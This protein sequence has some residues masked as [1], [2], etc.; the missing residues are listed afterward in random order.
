MTKELEG[1]EVP[2]Q[3]RT[4]FGTFTL[5]AA[6]QSGALLLFSS[7]MLGEIVIPILRMGEKATSSSKCSRCVDLPS[8]RYLKTILY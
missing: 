7:E 6:G 1:F 4:P 2:A 5:E 3:G 8:H